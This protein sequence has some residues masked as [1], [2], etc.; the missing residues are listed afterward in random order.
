MPGFGKF[1]VKID[2][3]IGLLNVSSQRSDHLDSRIVAI[4][5]SLCEMRVAFDHSMQFFES[6]LSSIDT[7]L[8]LHTVPKLHADGDGKVAVLK[9]MFEKTSKTI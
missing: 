7:K 4:E 2:E 1:E 6:R 3:I 8:D 5:T 9:T